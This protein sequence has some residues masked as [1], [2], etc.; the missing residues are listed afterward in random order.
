METVKA[1]MWNYSRNNPCP[2]CYGWDLQFSSNCT[3]RKF[4]CPKCG[5][6][7]AHYRGLCKTCFLNSTSI[8]TRSG[9]LPRI[10][11]CP[12]CDSVACAGEWK[13]VNY[14]EP[15]IDVHPAIIEAFLSENTFIGPVSLRVR[16]LVVEGA[17]PGRPRRKRRGTTPPVPRTRSEG[18]VPRPRWP[19]RTER[20][21]RQR[22]QLRR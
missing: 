8:R 19:G 3:H 21:P 7:E 11:F 15:T 17:P 16:D 6:N 5:R 4:V 9:G 13:S 14:W 22:R 2:T 10:T 1:M 12:K 18:G 20:A